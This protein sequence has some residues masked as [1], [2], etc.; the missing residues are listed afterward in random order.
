MLGVI[1]SIIWVVS[2]IPQTI[3]LLKTKSS[4]NISITWFCFIILGSFL[5]L[6]ASLNP[7]N[8]N[9][10]ISN[11]ASFISSFINFILIIK[12]RDK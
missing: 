12:Y 8:L 2:G 4:K 7:F 6:V 3:T 11:T 9:L 1:I 10:V 5:S